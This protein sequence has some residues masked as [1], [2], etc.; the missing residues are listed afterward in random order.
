MVELA[1]VGAFAV[2]ILFGYVFGFGHGLGDGMAAVWD[3]L[4]EVDAS[5]L[6]LDELPRTSARVFVFDEADE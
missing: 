6:E 1:L 2:G 4:R 3:S 5:G